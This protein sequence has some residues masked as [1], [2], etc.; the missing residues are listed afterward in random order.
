M[1]K[2]KERVFLGVPTY[3]GTI[4]AG[5]LPA[6]I[7]ASQDGCTMYRTR[8]HS[9][10]AHNFN[11]LYTEALNGRRKPHEYTHFV[12]LHS[13]IIPEMGWLGKML[14]IMA[15]TKAGVLAAVSPMKSVKGLTSTGV[16]QGTEDDPF[17]VQ[18]LTM[19]EIHRLPETFTDPK[20]VV[21]SGLL[22]VDIRQPWADQVFFEIQSRIARLKNGDLQARVHSEDWYFSRQVR[23]LGGSIYATRAVRLL[24]VGRHEYSNAFVWGTEETDPNFKSPENPA[25][26][27]KEG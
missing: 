25:A 1:S 22:L 7:N 14:D 12:L 24:H 13:D 26:H 8:G 15:E 18:R 20:L 3:D 17:L 11:V 19:T 6:V 5:L 21:N 2:R 27:K 9:L 4:V 16:D 10:L 23:A